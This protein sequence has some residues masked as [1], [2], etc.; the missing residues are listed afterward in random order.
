MLTLK[1]AAQITGIKEH[2]LRQRYYRR[3]VRLKKTKGR[4]YM[5]E[6]E[7]ERLVV[8]QFETGHA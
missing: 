8:L 6:F 2:L 7:V 3:T 4:F 1:E 5:D